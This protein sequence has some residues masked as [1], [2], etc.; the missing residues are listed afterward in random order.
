[1]KITQLHLKDFQQFKDLTLDFTH[2]K[3]GEPLKRVCFIGR[4]GTGKTTIL[5]ILY[6]GVAEIMELKNEDS[7]NHQNFKLPYYI[8]LENGHPDRKLSINFEDTVNQNPYNQ[9]IYIKSES[10]FSKQQLPES[11]VNEALQLFQNFPNT[12]EVSN[13]TVNDFWKNLIFHIKKRE[14]DRIEFENQEYNLSKT[15]RQ[16]IKEFSDKHPEIL[17]GL[18]QLWDKILAQAGLYFDTKNASRPIQLTDN[19]FVY[20]KSKITGETIPYYKLS[21]GI[22]N[23]IFRIGHLYSI[24]FNQKE[25]QHFLLI[26]EPSIG[27]FPDFIYNLIEFY[28]TIVPPKTQFFIATHNPIIAAQFEPYERYILDFNQ[29]GY[30]TVKRGI[31]PIGDDPNDI[32]TDDFLVEYIMPKQG[33]EAWNRYKKLKREIRILSKKGTSVNGE[34]E[35]LD[36]L[37][38]EMSE[39]GRKYNF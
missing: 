25:G 24:F 26:D 6:Q 7:S 34:K 12:H 9:L 27:L 1:M 19:L 3:T 38:E 37:I 30:V 8:S 10:D 20:I 28:E 18:A 13:Q 15:K 22:K 4:N 39:L 17:E 11:T 5:D 33:V 36:Q 29:E 35:K 14:N 21:A 32:L 16:L 31:S 23:F 2:P